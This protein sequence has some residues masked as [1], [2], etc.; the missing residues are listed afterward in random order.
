MPSLLNHSTWLPAKIMEVNLN[1]TFTIKYFHEKTPFT[2]DLPPSSYGPG[3]LSTHTW[4]NIITKKDTLDKQNALLSTERALFSTRSNRTRTEEDGPRCL[5]GYRCLARQRILARHPTITPLQ[6]FNLSTITSDCPAGLKTSELNDA[7]QAIA[8]S[9]RTNSIIIANSITSNLPGMI[10]FQDT[11]EYLNNR[12]Q[13]ISSLTPTSYCSSQQEYGGEQYCDMIALAIHDQ[14][15][16]YNL[17]A[18]TN[19]VTVAHPDGSLTSAEVSTI[20]PLPSDYVI[21]H[22]WRGTQF[23]S[24][25]PKTTVP[26]PPLQTLYSLILSKTRLFLN[27]PPLLPTHLP[28]LPRKTLHPYPPPRPPHNTPSQ[29]LHHPPQIPFPPTQTA[30]E[31]NIPSLLNK[32]K[33][34]GDHA[35]LHGY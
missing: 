26:I 31:Q 24:Y 7:L 20:S 28:T 3:N 4:F 34:I 8:R 29:T 33:P 10:T 12:S 17:T 32:L 14:T 2:A 6:R 35:A 25:L 21:E 5:C 16:I 27:L 13:M 30:H 22:T 15:T 18:G 11:I 9:M 1:E 23:E 19:T